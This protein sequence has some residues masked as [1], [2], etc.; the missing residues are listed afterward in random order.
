VEQSD[1]LVNLVLALGAGLI[2]ALFAARLG[3]SVILGY[4]LAGIAIGGYTPGFVGDQE[5][6]NALADI[7]IILLMFAIGVEF[8]LAE[9]LHSGKIA[10]I[11]AGIQIAVTIGL[12]YLVGIALGWG[13][14]ESVFFGAVL[15]ASSSL[16][17]IKV[18]GEQG[19][20]DAPH[21]R[22]ALAW[23]IVQDLS[24]VILIV[25][26][27]ALASDSD[28][29]ARELVVEL[30]KAGLFLILLIPVGLR[31][32]PWTFDWI[33]SLRSREVFVLAVGA[34]AL[35]LAYAATWFGLSLALGAFV[36]GIVVGE[37]DLSH[38]ILGEILPLR[39]IFAGLF[40]V[41]IGML[42][43]LE[44]AAEHLLLILLAVALIVLVKSMLA[45][46][47]SVVM[48][49]PLR[50]AIL[51][52]ALLGQCAEFSFLLARV[53]HDLG[54]VGETAFNVMLAGSAASIVL[55]PAAFRLSRP[56]ATAFQHRFPEADTGLLLAPNHDPHPDLRAHA[57]ICGYGHVG[58]V[59]GDV[60]SRQGFRYVVVDE[61]ARI[62]RRAVAEGIPAVIGNAS[63]P[64]VLE[65][66]NPGRARVL[67]VSIPDPVATRILVDYVRRNYPRLD[68]VVRTHNEEERRQ[69][70]GRGVNEVILAEWELALEMT[71]HTLHRLGVESLTSGQIINRMRGR[72]EIEEEHPVME[73]V[74]PER[75]TIESE[76]RRRRKERRIR[77]EPRPATRRRQ[78]ETEASVPAENDSERA[79]SAGEPAGP[80]ERPAR[81]PR[82]KNV[83]TSGG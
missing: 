82:I 51:A 24:T 16:V 6:V 77:G 26:L 68:V 31:V 28:Q 74:M 53:G 63:L 54:S 72:I 19:E 45:A 35:G 79:A 34:A 20:S 80:E 50:T 76:W 10:T 15:S 49:S 9:L 37:S 55:A 18:A 65:Q 69:L 12:G 22:L 39:D 78:G 30:G 33:A 46:G 64:A 52:G 40:F 75:R 71:R 42:I 67:V 27:S 81:K 58:H 36:A 59:I 66:T 43:D 7:G 23:S 73:G 38:Q 57:V 25:L 32:L 56:V 13:S 41:S 70:L 14:L 5:T 47:I 8:S 44:F 83:R 3:Q 1:L 17:L 48:G 60:L 2:G 29:L 21:A 62:A 11:G 61:D 4:I